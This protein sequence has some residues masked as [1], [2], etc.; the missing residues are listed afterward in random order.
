M[1]IE[2]EDVLIAHGKIAIK[3]AEKRRDR[4]IAFQ[5]QEVKKPT[6]ASKL[7]G[8]KYLAYSMLLVHHPSVLVPSCLLF[9]LHPESV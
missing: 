9:S 1:I 7:A 4:W 8:Y 3:N 5:L 6:L 2:D